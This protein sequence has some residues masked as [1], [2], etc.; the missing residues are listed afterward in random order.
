MFT[1]EHPFAILNISLLVDPAETMYIQAHATA[2][3][4]LTNKASL[5]I[6]STYPW[7]TLSGSEISFPDHSALP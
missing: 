4:L 1:G 3:K 6:R 5:T 7:R 2:H